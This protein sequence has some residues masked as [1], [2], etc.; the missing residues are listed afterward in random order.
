MPGDVRI[1]RQ[2]AQTKDPYPVTDLGPDVGSRP[3]EYQMPRS[4]AKL[5][6][7]RFFTWVRPRYSAPGDPFAPT[8]MLPPPWVS[9]MAVP[10]AT[11]VA[12]PMYAPAQPYPPT[13]IPWQAAPVPANAPPVAIY[14]AYPL[15]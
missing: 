8:S 13:A 12:S 11:P 1:E 14:P 10:S 7:D 4:E 3:L 15:Y 9:G 5:A 2:A 6:K